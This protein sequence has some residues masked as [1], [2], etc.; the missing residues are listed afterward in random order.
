MAKLAQT[1]M[2]SCLAISPSKWICKLLVFIAGLNHW[3]LLKFHAPRGVSATSTLRPMHEP[4][5]KQ[6]NSAAASACRWNRVALGSSGTSPG[7]KG[8]KQLATDFLSIS[9]RKAFGWTTD[10]SRL[11][12]LQGHCT[13]HKWMTFIMRNANERATGLAGPACSTQASFMLRHPCKQCI[14]FL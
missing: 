10:P 8:A 6:T 1:E 5:A 13:V 9:R 7:S 14:K 2:T 3:N 11:A 4:F 12:C